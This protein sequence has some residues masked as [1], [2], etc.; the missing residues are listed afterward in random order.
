MLLQGGDAV[1]DVAI[2]NIGGVDLAETVQRRVR[3]ARGFQRQPQIV[4]QRQRRFLFQSGTCKARLY[5]SEA[6]F[7]SPLSMN[8]SPSITEQFIS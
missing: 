6:T 7:G 5:H 3:F 1:G 2:I 4:A 8:E